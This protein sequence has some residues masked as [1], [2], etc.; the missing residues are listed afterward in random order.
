[1][2][3]FLKE[4]GVDCFCQGCGQLYDNCHCNDDRA[5]GDVLSYSLGYHANS[6]YDD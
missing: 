5:Y 3:N 6:D 4:F 2:K 1:M